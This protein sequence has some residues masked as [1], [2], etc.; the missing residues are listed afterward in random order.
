MSD[1]PEKPIDEA[2]KPILPPAPG[3]QAKQAK[4]EDTVAPQDQ[5]PPPDGETDTPAPAGETPAAEEKA[6]V[7][8]KII[9]PPPSAS[10]PAEQQPPRPLKVAQAPVLPPRPAAATSGSS[11]GS[12]AAMSPAPAAEGNALVLAF[13]F[14][15]AAVAITF[16]TLILIDLFS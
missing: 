16:A 6:V 9:A 1:Q 4:A 13:D 5:A 14:I 3:V 8:P 7:K 12:Q 15:V 10:R 11:S 2:A